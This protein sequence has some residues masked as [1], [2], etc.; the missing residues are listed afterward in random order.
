MNIEEIIYTEVESPVKD[1]A[2][3]VTLSDE[4]ISQRRDKVLARMKQQGLDKLVIYGDVEHGANFSYLVGFFTRFEEALLV[5]DKNGEMTLMLGNENLNKCQKS[6][7]ECTGV[8]VSLFSLPNQPNRNDKSFPE[9]LK[10]AGLEAGQKVGLVGWKHFTSLADP[11]EQLFDMPSFIVDAV[12]RVVGERGEV[13][14]Q[15]ALFI[16]EDGVRTINNANEIAHY[17]YGAALASDGI[18]D[19]MN[20]FDVGVTEMELAGEMVKG[21]QHTSVVTIAAAGERFLKGNMFPSMRKVETGVPVSLTVGYAGGLSS[22]AGYAAYDESDLPENARQYL[23][24]LAKP[25][26]A[27]YVSWLESVQIGMK[28]GELFERIDAVLPRKEYHWSLCPGH[29]C[30]EEEW[31]SS[32]VYE[33]SEEVLK[34]GMIFQIDIIP[35]RDGMAGTC[36]ESTVVLAD[37]TLK[38]DLQREYPQMWE[39]MG[40]RKAYLQEV[41]NI[42]L[43][44][45]VLPMCSTVA[46]MRPYLLNKR[47]AFAVKKGK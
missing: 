13:S 18:L 37:E 8:H 39:R 11:S 38:A 19:A 26:F 47:C 32:P 20:R 4:T 29:L 17:E 44:E 23:E 24:K 10:E 7:V 21:G 36:A 22:R 42:D 3:P 16:G 28:G 9:L 34:S 6:R 12:R 30:A 5:I 43:S 14:S 31:L 25:Y 2:E 41:L 46:Y 45:D 40:K 27:A 33:G 35:S 15:T 1:C